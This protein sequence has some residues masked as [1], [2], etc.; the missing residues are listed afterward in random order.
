LKFC[1]SKVEPLTLS[2]DFSVEII[3]SSF[4]LFV[5]DN[6]VFYIEPIFIKVGV[7]IALRKSTSFS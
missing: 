3:V 7:S 4:K 2:S 1:L 6:S 5:L